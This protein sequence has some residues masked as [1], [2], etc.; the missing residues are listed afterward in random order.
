MTHNL[1][2]SRSDTHWVTVRTTDGSDWC[3]VIVT[4][5]KTSDTIS[6]S[7][8]IRLTPNNARD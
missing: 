4:N 3:D 7:M 5:L 6:F 2:S 8:P 1:V